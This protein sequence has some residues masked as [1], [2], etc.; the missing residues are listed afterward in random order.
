MNV[1]MLAILIPIWCVL[2][3]VSGLMGF[4]AAYA[5]YMLYSSLRDNVDD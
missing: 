2:I 5:I 3:F 1:V 4:A